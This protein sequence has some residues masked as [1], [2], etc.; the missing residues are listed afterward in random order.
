VC[1]SSYIA[2]GRGLSV[3]HGDCGEVDGRGLRIVDG[4]RRHRVGRADGGLRPAAYETAHVAMP[5][6]TIN[7]VKLPNLSGSSP[8]I[9]TVVPVDRFGVRAAWGGSN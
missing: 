3:G 5:W 8:I 4:C 7:F 1:G 2:D 9:G 6:S